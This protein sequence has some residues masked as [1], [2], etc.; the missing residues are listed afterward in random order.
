[1][2]TAWNIEAKRGRNKQWI[3]RCLRKYFC[4]KG[5]FLIQDGAVKMSEYRR[6]K[7]KTG[8]R[9]EY[10]HAKVSSIDPALQVGELVEGNSLTYFSSLSA[11]EL[12]SRGNK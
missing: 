6:E 7:R 12:S 9:F 8:D 1:M 11:P 4:I 5:I 10:E 3:L 2:G